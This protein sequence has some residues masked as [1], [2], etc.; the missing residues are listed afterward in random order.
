MTGTDQDKRPGTDAEPTT[1]DAPGGPPP[2]GHEHMNGPG[3][4]NG[5]PDG[6]TEEDATGAP[7]SDRQQT[8]TLGG[9]AGAQPD[10]AANQDD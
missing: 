8:E 1:T 3:M 2:K 7:N 10:G 6:A 9:A 4:T 5:V